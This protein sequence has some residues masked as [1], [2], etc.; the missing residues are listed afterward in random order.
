MILELQDI[1]FSLPFLTVVW[2]SWAWSFVLTYLQTNYF[3]SN[4]NRLHFFFLASEPNPRTSKKATQNFYSA[5]KIGKIL[6]WW[7][8]SKGTQLVSFCNKK[9]TLVPTNQRQPWNQSAT[10]RK[11]RRY[12]FSVHYKR[13]TDICPERYYHAMVANICVGVITAS[14]RNGVLTRQT[15]YE[16]SVW[17]KFFTCI[18]PH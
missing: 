9:K 5:L 8:P 11:S 18:G 2:M 16:L 1:W 3:L 4:T 15:Q 12:L 6:R 13:T 17:D 14:A 10:S 7:W